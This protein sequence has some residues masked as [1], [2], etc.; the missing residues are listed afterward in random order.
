MS[1]AKEYQLNIG[2]ILQIPEDSFDNFLIDLK[3]WHGAVRRTV[4][5]LEVVA[6]ASNQPMP[7]ELVTMKWIDDGKHEGKI[8]IKSTPPAAINKMGSK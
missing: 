1:K 5:M 7:K 8:I 6:K 4:D 2:D 3:K